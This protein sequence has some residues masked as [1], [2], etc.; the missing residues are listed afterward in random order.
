M[1]V[2]TSHTCIIVCT[3]QQ[4]WIPHIAY[5]CVMYRIHGRIT[6]FPKFF[7]HLPQGTYFLSVSG[8]CNLFDEVYHRFVFKSRWA[9]LALY[10]PISNWKHELLSVHTRD[11]NPNSPNV[12][13]RLGSLPPSTLYNYK[14]IRWAT[15]YFPA[16]WHPRSFAMTAG[17]RISW[18]SSEYWYA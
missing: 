3:Q 10:M 14:T 11:C 7:S 17:I 1:S 13:N 12:A 15:H 4:S 5:P 8:M 2:V 9:R 6:I 16:W 18:R